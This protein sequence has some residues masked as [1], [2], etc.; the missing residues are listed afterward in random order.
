MARDGMGPRGWPVWRLIWKGSRTFSL[1]E[2]K[3]WDSMGRDGMEWGG[4]RMRMDEWM[5]WHGMGPG[6]GPMGRLMWRNQGISHLLPR[7]AQG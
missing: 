6:G 4:M 7:R 2:P 5:A 1:E 3:G